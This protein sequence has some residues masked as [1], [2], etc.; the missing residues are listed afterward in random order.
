MPP[1]YSISF[2]GEA[3]AQA[4]SFGGLGPAILIAIFGVLAVLL[5]EFG[6]FAVTAS[7]RSSFR[8]ASWAG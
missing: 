4:R 5:L 1:G 7:S 8:S 2:G 6:T 3:E